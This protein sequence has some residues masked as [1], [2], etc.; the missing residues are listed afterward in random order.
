[1]FWTTVKRYIPFVILVILSVTAIV[2]FRDYLTFES[3]KE[4]RE[5]LLQYRDQ[6]PVLAPITF[7]LLYITITALSVPGAVFVTLFGGFLFPQPL[8]TIYVL[9]GA[10][11]GASIIFLAAKTAFGDLLREKAGPV[12]QKM[13]S[14][15][16]ENAVSYL[17]F[18]RFIPIFPFW[19]VNLAPAFFGVTLW[20]FVW[21]TFIGIL[22]GSAVYTQVGAG[23][24]AILDSGEEFSISA[25]F[26][27]KLRIA[28]IALGLFVLIPVIVKKFRKKNP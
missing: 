12:L 25:V 8:S 28:L 1:M 10:T 7:I 22:P 9:I 3:L 20:T 17:L 6:Y 2:Y 13:E 16:R 19:L 14:G 24:G 26:N 27:W 4:K 23:L 5:A 21:T 15:F 18:L 11:I